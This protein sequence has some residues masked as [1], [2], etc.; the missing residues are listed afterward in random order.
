[1]RIVNILFFV[2]L[3]YSGLGLAAVDM[4]N[5]PL[6]DPMI[7]FK[8]S[9]YVKRTATEITPAR[10]SDDV[11]K[12]KYSELNLSP[13]IANWSSG[14]KMLFSTSSR[15]INLKFEL[16]GKNSVTFR[17]YR[18]GRVLKDYR[19]VGLEKKNPVE[20]RWESPDGRSHNY[21]VDLPTNVQ[22]IITGIELDRNAKLNEMT[23]P[24]KPIYIALGDS[25][26]HGSA[27][28]DGLAADS[29]ACILAN[30]LNYDL[31]N[32]AV[33]ASKVSV[34][35]GEMLKDW[36]KIDL[37]TLLIGYNDFSWGGVSVKDYKAQYLKLLEAIRKHHPSVP[38]FCI[39]LTYTRT[40][41][42]EK[43]GVTADEYRNAVIEIVKS[44]QAEGDKELFL[45]HGEKLSND[46]C[47]NDPVH[48]N[49]KGN[50][51]FADGLYQAI[52]KMLKN[53]KTQ[54]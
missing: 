2:G 22:A 3:L 12:M 19:F 13:S 47:L 33:G 8:G 25:V 32:L 35:V 23:L 38:I 49:V 16:I 39:T 48:F 27:A 7:Y 28:L 18:D 52:T 20:I 24:V 9:N 45:I 31:Y 41:K 5:V 29:Y 53:R 30:K 14:V 46:S 6:S 50:K 15:N 37:I 54:P 17:V 36:G 40:E 26:T 44:R 51:T 21:Q 10:F 11:L 43:T 4:Q 42:S 1:M 34:P